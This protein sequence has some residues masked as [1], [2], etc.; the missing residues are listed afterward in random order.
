MNLNVLKTDSTCCDICSNDLD[1]YIQMTL[2][3]IHMT[4]TYIYMTLTCIHMTLTYIHMTLHV[5]MSTMSTYFLHTTD[6]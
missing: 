6:N 4:L 5:T 1:I 2:T 3:Y